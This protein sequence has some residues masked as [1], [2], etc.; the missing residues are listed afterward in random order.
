MRGGAGKSRR[1][2][3]LE[4]F[5]LRVMA[6]FSGLKANGAPVPPDALAII[7]FHGYGANTGLRFRGRVVEKSGIVRSEG[8]DFLFRNAHRMWKRFL[9]R[10]VGAATVQV[11][12]GSVVQ[13]VTT[14]SQGFFLADLELRRPL[15][16]GGLHRVRLELVDPRPTPP[17]QALGSVFVPPTDARI[18]VISDIDDTILPAHATHPFKMFRLLLFS[19]ASARMPF[20]GVRSFYRALH[21]GRSRR[22]KNPFF[23]VSSCSWEM[24]DVLHDFVTLHGLPPGPIFLRELALAGPVRDPWRHGRKLKRAQEVLRAYPWLMFVL[25]GDSGQ[26]DAEIYS[27]LVRAF[28]GRI[29]AVY[30]RDVL[31][32]EGRRKRIAQIA[33]AVKTMGSEL[34]LVQDTM[35]AALHAASRG[36]ICE[37]SLREIEKDAVHGRARIGEIGI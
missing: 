6:F 28:P 30:I 20:A 14:T 34:L 29:P 27:L 12:S 32:T 2:H 24:H 23:Y 18:G 21:E 19:S 31:P 5:A 7:P 17:V 26:R 33:A 37:T 16:A 22:E 10:P 3:A 9:T 35:A 13:W 36:W 11:E 4:R 8:R 15:A 25:I 1:G